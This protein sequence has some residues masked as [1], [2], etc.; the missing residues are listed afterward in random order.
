MTRSENKAISILITGITGFIGR[1][2][3]Y[4]LLDNGFTVYGL[5]R[6]SKK[7]KTFFGDRVTLIE[8]I[9]AAPSVSFDVIVNLAGEPLAAA[10]WNDARKQI[11]RDSRINTTQQ[12]L[13]F[14]KNNART[15]PLLI[16]ASAIGIYGDRGEE[17]LQESSSIGD[18]F[19]ARMC[20]D[21][22]MA[23][24]SFSA[25]NARVCILRFGVVLGVGGGALVKMLP[26]FRAGVGGRLG[27]GQQW[28]SWIHLDDLTRLI[29]FCIENKQISG[30]INAVAPTPVKNQQ[31]TEALGAVLHRPVILPMPSLVLR[32]LVGEMADALLLA[33][34][35]VQPCVALQQGFVY[36]YPTIA[37]ALSDILET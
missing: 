15:L 27:D 17:I 8:A 4:R 30:N 18:D 12:I 2:L 34:Q 21:W 9:N 3:T 32:L 29:I 23:A 36:E 37:E 31:F 33:S 22:E 13:N 16:N 5:T 19:S 24:N 28:M 7:A 25:I 11:F 10:R 35:R 1:H 26:P 20:R 14:F 6:D